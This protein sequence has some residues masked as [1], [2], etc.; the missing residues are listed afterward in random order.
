MQAFRQLENCMAQVSANNF[1]Y[2]PEQGNNGQIRAE[3]CRT[4]P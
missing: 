4:G 3:K 1:L 2:F